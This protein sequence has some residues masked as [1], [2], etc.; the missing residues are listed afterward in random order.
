M[1]NLRMRYI[2][3]QKLTDIQFKRLTGISWSTFI[4]LSKILNDL[5]SV[6]LHF[7]CMN[8]QTGFVFI[9]HNIQVYFW[10]FTTI[11]CLSVKV[12]TALNLLQYH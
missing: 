9:K 10:V 12:L 4:D 2:D 8:V 5:N 7:L 6:H 3:I 11:F 1:H